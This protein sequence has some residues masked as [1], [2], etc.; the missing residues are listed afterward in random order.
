MRS[1]G[2]MA[3]TLCP[4]VR[5]SAAILELE[6][7]RRPMSDIIIP[8]AAELHEPENYNYKR[9]VL[10]K[11]ARS[12]MELSGPTQFVFCFLFCCDVPF[13]Y[14]FIF[15]S[16]FLIYYNYFV[17]IPAFELCA[18]V[19]IHARRDLSTSTWSA[20]SVCVLKAQVVTTK[21]MYRHPHATTVASPCQTLR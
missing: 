16:V 11:L 7:S 18:S 14:F 20:R 8:T 13:I 9:A 5:L 19:I 15:F 2:Y 21:N 4:S 12:R 1:K 10:L 17:Y 6:G 3:G